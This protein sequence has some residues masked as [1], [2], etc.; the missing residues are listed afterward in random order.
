M[1]KLELTEDELAFLYMMMDK[2]T[3]TGAANL[4][5]AGAVTEK[6]H[7]AAPVGEQV[8]MTNF[9]VID[10]GEGDDDELV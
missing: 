9:H 3:I 2:I 1:I 7:A 4:V 10:D 8:D 6:L 5:L